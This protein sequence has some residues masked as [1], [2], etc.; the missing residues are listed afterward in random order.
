MQATFIIHTSHLFAISEVDS[1]NLHCNITQVKLLSPPSFHFP[2]QAKHIPEESTEMVCFSPASFQEK[3]QAKDEGG[4]NHSASCCASFIVFHLVLILPTSIW[5]LLCSS[6]PQSHS[7]SC[8][9]AT[10]PVCAQCT[11]SSFYTR[12]KKTWMPMEFQA[13]EKS[14]ML[15][16][17]FKVTTRANSVDFQEG[18]PQ[19]LGSSHADWSQLYCYLYLVPKQKRR[20][21]YIH[22]YSS[23]LPTVQVFLSRSLDAPVFHPLTFAWKFTLHQACRSKQST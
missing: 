5:F 15:N 19:I 16:W 12:L 6:L 14:A 22:N 23:L 3:P 13:P 2:L 4:E 17:K 8:T 10:H 18:F 11:S 1:L 20:E 9:S 7:N 21:A